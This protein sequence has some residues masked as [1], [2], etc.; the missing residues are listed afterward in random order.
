VVGV[1]VHVVVSARGLVVWEATASA[2]HGLPRTR[3]CC[4]CC[5]GLARLRPPLPHRPFVQSVACTASACTTSRA[6]TPATAETT[7]TRWSPRWVAKRCLARLLRLGWLCNGR[8]S[9]R[10]AVWSATPKYQQGEFQGPCGSSLGYNQVII[11][12]RRCEQMSSFRGTVT[13]PTH[14]ANSQGERLRTPCPHHTVSPHSRS[15]LS[16]ES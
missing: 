5:C 8:L 6:A 12:C 9:S 16:L 11:R 7:S 2:Q 15:V 10:T 14:R 4:G 1:R 13:P 3:C